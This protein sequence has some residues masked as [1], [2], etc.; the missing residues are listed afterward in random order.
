MA[1]LTDETLMAY[2]DGALNALARAKVEA[3]L[4][5]DMEARRRL[6][7]F[8][9]TGHRLS[10][11]YGKPM[12]EPV[13]AY[14]RDFVL[15]FPVEERAA[16]PEAPAAAAKPHTR[17]LVERLSAL[18]LKA[19]RGAPDIVGSLRRLSLKAKPVA[20]GVSAWLADRVSPAA[21][22][23][24]GAVSAAT[25]A[26]SL[27]LG[28]LAH[29]NVQPSILVSFED[30][31]V[32]ASGTLHRVLEETPSTEETRIAGLR[33]SDAVTM[34]ANLTFK[35]KQGAW[36]RE[37]EISAEHSGKYAG[38]GCR[39]ADGRW[40]L[41]V[42]VPAGSIKRQQLHPTPAAHTVELDAFVTSVMSGDALGRE[43]E[44][45]AI[46]GGWK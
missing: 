1:R 17:K 35:T 6:E 2:A 24:L 34:R 11:L 27:G 45:A 39:E 15:N 13:P 25:I 43:K 36:C 10:T 23:Q 7:A 9:A 29:D 26:V 12:A 20:E 22:W 5:I 46:A 8:R 21:R 40:A 3:V 42:N 41:E 30:G 4:Q 44:A 18:S 32:Y 37:Y 31:R 16:F 14:L 19:K 38:L 33:A 28:W